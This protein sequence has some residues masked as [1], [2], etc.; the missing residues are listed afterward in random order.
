MRLTY[1]VLAGAMASAP[2]GVPQENAPVAIDRVA[3]LQGCWESVSPQRTVEEQWMSPRGRSMIGVGR[4]VRGD[5]LVE[6]ELVVLREQGGQLAYQ[7]HP[8][9]QPSATFLSKTVSAT[10]VLFENAAHDFPQRVGYRRD[11]PDALLAWIEGTR[12]GQ[13][14]RVEFPYRRVTCPGK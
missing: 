7:A 3:W 10:E 14:R 6:Y 5:A 8:S 4:T 11:G 12:N 9:G 1:L 2:G 13:P